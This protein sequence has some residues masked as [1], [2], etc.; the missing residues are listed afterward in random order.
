MVWHRIYQWL[1]ISFIVP[2]SVRDHLQ[3]GHLARLPRST[4]FS[5]GNLDGYCLGYLEGK[6]QQDF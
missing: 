5:D 2:T 4:L 3:F 1:G 6:K